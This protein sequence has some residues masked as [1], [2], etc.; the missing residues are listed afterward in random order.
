MKKSNYLALC[1]LIFPLVS[2]GDS[3]P[4]GNAT[5]EVNEPPSSLQIG[6]AK[7]Q[8]T[9]AASL[10]MIDSGVPREAIQLVCD[11][12]ID[13]LVDDGNYAVESEPSEAESD[14]AMNV[15]INEISQEMGV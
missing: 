10:G 4:S 12:T 13:K 5:V 8:C 3:P 6:S 1:A 11:C 9:S 15:C 7:R 2:C 14:E